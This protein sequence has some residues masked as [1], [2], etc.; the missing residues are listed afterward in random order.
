MI[1]KNYKNTD[2]ANKNWFKS[3]FNKTKDF[4]VDQVAVENAK[5]LHGTWCKEVNLLLK[6]GIKRKDNSLEFSIGDLTEDEFLF[7]KP[8]IKTDNSS[9]AWLTHYI[10]SDFAKHLRST[11]ALKWDELSDWQQLLNVKIATKKLKEKKSKNSD[12]YSNLMDAM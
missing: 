5:E 4:M 12:Y 2:K 3:E 8:F 6:K 9:C 1:K 10:D 11:A 7:V